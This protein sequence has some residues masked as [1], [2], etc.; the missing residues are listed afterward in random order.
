MQIS[1]DKT[2]ENMDAI[3]GILS[4]TIDKVFELANRVDDY[5]SPLLVGKRSFKETIVH[6]I[7]CDIVFTDEV[8]IGLMKKNPQ[9][10]HVHPERDVGKLLKL[11]KM[12]TKA[13]LAY[14]KARREILLY[15]LAEIKPKDWDKII[16][17][18]WKKTNETVYRK[19]RVLAVHENHHI[20]KMLDQIEV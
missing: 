14:F 16:I 5:D 6:M 10:E 1:T 13:L 12:D 11:G 4:T 3:L 8:Y 7:N 9:V 17:Q 15:V 2:Q 20:E 19:L 18:P